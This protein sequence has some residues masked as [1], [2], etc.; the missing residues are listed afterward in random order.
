MST[1]FYCEVILS[2]ETRIDVWALA[3][4]A[5]KLSLSKRVRFAFP[6]LN[7]PL[8]ARIAFTIFLSMLLSLV[9]IKSVTPLRIYSS[10]LLPG[11]TPNHPD[12]W[13]AV[14]EIFR[15]KFEARKSEILRP[16]LALLLYTLIC[17][18]YTL[19]RERKK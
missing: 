19:E 12:D 5:S 6:L 9:G 14:K 11:H 7:A 16:Q 13:P 4:L 18:T 1:Q 10:S 8:F 17:L 2:V 3:V 15:S